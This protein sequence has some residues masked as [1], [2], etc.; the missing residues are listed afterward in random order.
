MS[1]ADPVV[2]EY[3]RAAEHYDEKWAFYL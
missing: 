2:D 3:A 1:P